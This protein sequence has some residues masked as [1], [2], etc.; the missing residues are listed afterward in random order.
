MVY[1]K[2]ICNSALEGYF[3]GFASR[4]NPNK[5]SEVSDRIRKRKRW[6]SK[7]NLEIIECDESAIDLVA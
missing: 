2:S 4:S 6:T 5:G 3:R 7:N 1:L